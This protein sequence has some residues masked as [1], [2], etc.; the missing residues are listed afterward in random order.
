MKLS[1][2]I[3]VT[4]EFKGSQTN[5]EAYMTDESKREYGSS[6]SFRKIS[7]NSVGGCIAKMAELC[8]WELERKGLLFEGVLIGSLTE[9]GRWY[10]SQESYLNAHRDRGGEMPAE[11]LFEWGV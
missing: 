2:N 4:T 6:F 7:S 5:V 1:F 10:S 8:A 3:K 11:M 9:G